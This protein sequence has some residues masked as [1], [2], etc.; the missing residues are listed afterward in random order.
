MLG[1]RL[2][3]EDEIDA[4]NEITDLETGDE[5]E[6]EDAEAAARALGELVADGRDTGEVQYFPSKLT[7]LKR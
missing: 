4:E 2:S 3:S 1:R 7:A 6:D 5:D